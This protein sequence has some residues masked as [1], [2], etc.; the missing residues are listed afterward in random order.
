MKRII[1]VLIL[2]ITLFIFQ[3]CKEQPKESQGQIS[4][5]IRLNQIGY[6][7]V[8]IKKAVV[9]GAIEVTDFQIVDSSSGK[10][11]FSASLSE[12]EKWELSGEDVRI[13]DFTGFEQ[14]GTY[15]INVN[16]MGRSYPFEIQNNVLKAAFLG[17]VKGLYYQR[18][19]MAL[20]EKYAGK[21]HRP[22]GHPDDS[23]RFH[24]SSGRSEGFLVSPK[25]WY[26]AGDY[27]KYVLNASFPLGQFYSLYEEY[28]EAIADGE[29]NIPESGNG[30]S[31]YLDE[32]KYEMD[33]VLSM[34][35]E[36]GGMF[37][38]LTT[39]GFEGMVMPDKAVSTRYVI[40][41]STGPTL[42][43]AAMAAQAHR[44]FHKSDPDY[45][46]V[47]LDASK[48]AYQWAKDNPDK[49]FTNPEDIS[50]GEYGD[51]D[52]SDEFFWAAAELY[53]STQDQQYLDILTETELDFNMK[54]GDGWRRY[55]RFLG[56]FSLLRNPDGVPEELI[57]KIRTGLLASA[58]ELVAKAQD[59]EYFQPIDDFQ[60][61]S[62]SDVLN[63]AMI[64]AQAYH[65]QPDKKYLFGA[66][67]AV[68]YV[69][70]NNAVGYSF[71]SG[72]GDKTPLFL[73]HRPSAADG[74]EESVPGLLSGGPNSRLQDAGNDVIYPDKVS[75]MKAWV[76]QE[77][78]YASNEICLNWNAP[79][80]YV[81]GFLEQESN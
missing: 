30:I 31:D 38:K 7:P 37:H 55:M 44:V 75:P 78:S 61:G 35:D 17:S 51:D 20:E 26:D 48:K 45:A 16:G 68:D 32:L 63:A 12:T 72:F 28:P 59:R 21:W 40:G 66:Q 71:L 4:E 62:N 33:W 8:S 70:G 50:T 77:P 54:P 47:C 67:Q 36:D 43:F 1:T 10:E 64:M 39:K 27:G 79:L 74:I 41:K 22:A 19:S 56:M 6:Y 13:A 49:A 23:V 15:Y 25:G 5:D 34:Q 69:L 29:L 14:E 46:N 52:F 57:Q 73:H 76:D 11:V 81:L 80:T 58:D 3:A 60:W 42:D 65:I 9:V 2:V 53:V 18:A 24:P